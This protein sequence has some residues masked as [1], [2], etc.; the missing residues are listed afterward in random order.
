MGHTLLAL[1]L[2]LVTG[3]HIAAQLSKRGLAHVVLVLPR[4]PYAE[5]VLPTDELTR[6]L[7]DLAP[8]PR[9]VATTNVVFVV[10]AE[11]S[12]TIVRPRQDRRA[13]NRYR[14]SPGDLPN[15][16]ALRRHGIQRVV[17]IQQR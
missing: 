11:R 16:A 2:E 3:I 1:D 12:A 7:L 9:P 5:A 10:D 4:W 8:R 15:L 13:D 17:K 14:L 6:A